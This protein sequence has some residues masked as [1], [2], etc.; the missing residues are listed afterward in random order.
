[1]NIFKAIGRAFVGIGKGILAALRFAE[2]HGLTDDLVDLALSHV[3]TAQVKFITNQERFDYV[4][5]R[6]QGPFVP[7]S[8][9]RLAVEL[10]GQRYKDA[11]SPPD[12]RP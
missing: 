9:A 3:A 7:E 12:V 6:I 2:K 4:V 1:M 10:A 8:V 5:G 11:I